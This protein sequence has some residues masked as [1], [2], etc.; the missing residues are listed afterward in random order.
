MP[1]IEWV[2]CYYANRSDTSAF[3]AAKVTIETAREMVEAGQATWS[4][5]CKYLKL[6]RTEASMT[7]T[8][9][10]LKVGP[11]VMMGYVLGEPRD[12]AIIESWRGI[13]A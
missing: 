2:A 13:A 12:V 8:A 10:S 3:P 11:E 5:G 1:E 4:K 9:R 7:P 6:T